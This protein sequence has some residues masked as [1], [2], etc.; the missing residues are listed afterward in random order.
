[1]AVPRSMTRVALLA[2]LAAVGA[3][4]SAAAAPTVNVKVK[5]VS[6][7]GFPHT[8]YIPGAGAAVE[9]QTTIQGTEYGG[10]PP[11]LIG[12][13]A[14]LPKGVM[15]HPQGFPV[16]PLVSLEKT[17]RCPAASRAGPLGHA[18]GVVS[19]GSE[20]VPEEVSVQPYLATGGLEFYVQGHS[21]VALELISRG[22]FVPASGLFDEEF[23]GE[24]PLVETVPGAPDAST[25]SIDV[26][27]GTAIKRNGKTLYY[28]KV[29]ETCPRGGYP[30]KSELM[31]AGLGGLA[32]QTVTTSLKVPCP[33]K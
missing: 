2:L 18:L 7:P 28:G 25:E 17:G 31:F 22:H 27:I 9:I 33:R 5:V 16:C 1:M 12:V 23:I 11:P 29:P 6:I 14:Y 32:P 24:V 21:P 19:F 15:V 30:V 3:P 4:V 20:R 13:I 8:G 10:F 26:T